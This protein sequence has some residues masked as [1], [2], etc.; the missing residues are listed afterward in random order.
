MVSILITAVKPPAWK[1][2]LLLLDRHLISAK[3]LR[4]DAVKLNSQPLDGCSY[5]TCKLPCRYF[6]DYIIRWLLKHYYAF[7]DINMISTFRSSSQFSEGCSDL[8]VRAVWSTFQM[9]LQLGVQRDVSEPMNP[10]T[11]K[12]VQYLRKIQIHYPLL[13]Q[14]YRN[15]NSALPRCDKKAQ[16]SIQNKASDIW[17]EDT[18][19]SI[20]THEENLDEDQSLQP[21][22]QKVNEPNASS[23]RNRPRSTETLGTTSNG[24][25]KAHSSV[26]AHQLQTVTS[27]W[28][29]EKISQT[30]K[31]HDF[32][33][34]VVPSG[35]MV[36]TD[37]NDEN[38][39]YCNQYTWCIS[40]H[41]MVS[42]V[43]RLLI[44]SYVT[45]LI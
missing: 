15:S 44:E 14:V 35:C 19:K 1:L 18:Q 6:M 24:E 29:T 32:F 41:Q 33:T 9:T 37:I 31:N 36:C 5:Y 2:V 22:K 23:T 43:S 38:Y 11:K 26:P 13:K 30:V 34:S 16:F 25:P 4:P 12:S 42:I 45:L 39:N 10:T 21:T 40:M 20:T 27:S 3:N 7:F 8:A 17:P 28:C